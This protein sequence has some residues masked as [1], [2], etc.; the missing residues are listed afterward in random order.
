MQLR[1]GR[2]DCF[3]GNIAQPVQQKQIK[4]EQLDQSHYEKTDLFIQEANVFSL[5]FP[6][7]SVLVVSHCMQHNFYT[8]CI[9]TVNQLNYFL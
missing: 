1:V 3:T 7:M 5:F 2:C 8:I 9:H 4:S 6:Y